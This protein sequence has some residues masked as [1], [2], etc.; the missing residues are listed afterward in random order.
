MLDL[1]LHYERGLLSSK[2]IAEHQDVSAKYL[3]HLLSCLRNAGLVRSI[4]GAQ[5]GH[6]LARSPA[7]IDLRQIF[8]VLEGGGGLVDCTQSPETCP[9]YD[10]CVT[11]EVWA[12]MYDACTEILETT[13]LADLVRRAKEKEGSGTVMYYI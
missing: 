7:E 10:G 6:E 13:T 4:R 2:E 3:E 12:R 1:A 5:G 8:E 11:Q 9:R